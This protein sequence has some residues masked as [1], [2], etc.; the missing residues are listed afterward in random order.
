[1]TIDDDMPVDLTDHQGTVTFQL[2]ENELHLVHSYDGI[3][4]YSDTLNQARQ[5]KAVSRTFDYASLSIANVNAR[6]SLKFLQYH[7]QMDT[8]ENFK[9]AGHFEYHVSETVMTYRRCEI[10]CASKLSSLIDEKHKF[11]KIANRFQ[12][13]RVW[14]QTNTVTKRFHGNTIYQIFLNH[15]MLYPKNTIST[16]Q[17]IRVFHYHNNERQALTSIAEMYSYY[18]SPSQSYWTRNAY[19]LNVALSPSASVYVYVPESDLHLVNDN[20]KEQCACYRFPTRSASKFQMLKESH[21]KLQIQQNELKF[22]IESGRLN[23]QNPQVGTLPALVYPFLAQEIP[24]KTKREKL[25]FLTMKDLNPLMPTNENQNLGLASSLIYFTAK[26][27]GPPLLVHF[28]K[29]TLKKMAQRLGS[30]LFMKLSPQENAIHEL[31]H[32]SGLNLT[33]ENFTLVL[34]YQ[35]IGQFS[36][37]ISSDISLTDTML[38]NLTL[39]NQIFGTFMTNQVH[40]VLLHM[41]AAAVPGQIDTNVPILGVVS[42]QNSFL[43]VDFYFSVFEES[44]SVTNYQTAPLPHAIVDQE[45]LSLNIPRRFSTQPSQ[46]AYIFPTADDKPQIIDAC[47]NNILGSAPFQ[48]SQL[49]QYE[50]FSD[51]QLINLF[52]IDEQRIFYAQGLGCAIKIVCPNQKLK[53]FQLTKQ[54]LVFMSPAVCTVTMVTDAGLITIPSNDTILYQSNLHIRPKMLFHYDLQ[55]ELGLDTKQTIILVILCVLVFLFILIILGMLYYVFH[56]QLAAAIVNTDAGS[57]ITITE[58]PLGLELQTE[59]RH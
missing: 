56:R 25:D 39:T 26:N 50:K 20:Y 6:E 53:V 38:R 9:L 4:L 7:N 51:R 42:Q 3:L 19:D 57:E 28:L 33:A 30:K 52:S 8:L 23:K 10:Y 35:H 5:I 36:K 1:M 59:I 54:I 2:N 16:N 14:V 24:N 49:C 12:F 43:L 21:Q 22:G 37:N 40:N 58:P 29:P 41:A 11:Y 15:H 45:F 18:D 17:K 32:V 55:N 48:M 44:Q 31:V 47:I 27:V 13:E 34:D 46:S